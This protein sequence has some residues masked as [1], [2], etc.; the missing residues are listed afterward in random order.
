MEKTIMLLFRG[1]RG[2]EHKYGNRR[3]SSSKTRQLRM[4]GADD[5]VCHCR[6]KH[7]TEKEEK[8]LLTV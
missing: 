4:Q 3:R 2:N 6:H 1:R 7:R 5:A 8:D